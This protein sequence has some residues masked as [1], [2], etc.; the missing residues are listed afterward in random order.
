MRKIKY[1]HVC[2]RHNHSDELF[3]CYG[4]AQGGLL[5]RH[6]AS[7]REAR[8]CLQEPTRV[9]QQQEDPN[10]LRDSECCGHALGNGGG[11]A[12]RAKLQVETRRLVFNRYGTTEYLEGVLTST[13]NSVDLETGDCG[14]G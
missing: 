10:I 11:T 13:G 14:E 8:N 4:A 5:R 2:G 1:A 6:S 12:V 7:T 3:A 9:R